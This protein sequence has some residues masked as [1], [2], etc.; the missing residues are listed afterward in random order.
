MNITDEPTD[1]IDNDPPQVS[2]IRIIVPGSGT[3]ITADYVYTGREYEL[4]AIASD[5]EG[6]ALHYQWS[7]ESE[8]G[9]YCSNINNAFSNPATWT[10]PDQLEDTIDQWC[11]ITVRVGDNYNE[12]QS[13]QKRVHVVT[14][15]GI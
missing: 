10:T 9:G 12:L 6:G 4:L 15:A 7:I 14:G 3:I 8:N 13:L 2:E 11:I 1:Q 5:P